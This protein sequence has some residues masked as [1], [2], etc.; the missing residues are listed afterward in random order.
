MKAIPYRAGHPTLP[1]EETRARCSYQT[2]GIL[3]AA[4]YVH[5]EVSSFAREE[6]FDSRH[7]RKNW[8]HIPYLGLDRPPIPSTAT[9]FAFG[10]CGASAAI[11]RTPREPSRRG[12]GNAD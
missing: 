2:R 11:C 1:D 6:Q 7:N 4:A 8:D 3:K 5:Y 10:I 12:A 9:G